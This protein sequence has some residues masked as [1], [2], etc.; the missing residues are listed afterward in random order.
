ML[1]AVDKVYNPFC[2]TVRQN[3]KF[4]LAFFSH[5]PIMPENFQSFPVYNPFCL[6]VRQNGK[7]A[8]ANFSHSPIMPEKFQSFPVLPDQTRDLPRMPKLSGI[9]G[10]CLISRFDCNIYMY[11]IVHLTLKAKNKMLLA[12]SK[13]ITKINK[14]TNI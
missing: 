11:K 7:F 4:A 1:H 8:Q 10:E 5:L 6:T 9:L 12:K 3:G 14:Q 2:L 13:I